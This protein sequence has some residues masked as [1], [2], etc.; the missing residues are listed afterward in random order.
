[1]DDLTVPFHCSDNRE[2]QL[3]HERGCLKAGMNYNNSAKMARLS[4]SLFERIYLQINITFKTK[5]FSVILKILIQ[6]RVLVVNFNFK[7]YR[8]KVA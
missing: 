3:Y 2:M 8:K 7:T 4:V 5:T 1:M 6:N